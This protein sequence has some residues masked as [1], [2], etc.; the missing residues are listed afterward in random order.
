[1]FDMMVRCRTSCELRTAVDGVVGVPTDELADGALRAELLLVAREID[2]LEHRRARLLAAIHRRG[3]PN[4]DGAGSTPAWAQHLT[5]QARHDARKAL[6]AG[7]V[8][9]TLPLTSKAW[10]QGEI[11][12]GAALAICHGRPQGH[13]DAY[14]AIEDTLVEFAS[15]HDWHGLLA[16]VA[17]ARRCAD[18]L[19]GKEPSDLNGLSHARVGDRW[20]TRAD[21]DGL[22]GKIVDEALCAA[23]DK[24][25]DDDTRTPSKRFA[26]ALVR[27]ARFFL[28][29]EDL[30]VEGGEKPH[31]G[32]V[33]DWETIAGRLPSAGEL[34][35]SLSAADIGTLL[36]DAQIER[37]I[38]GAKRQPLDI[39]RLAHDVPKPMRRA[40]AARDRCCRFPGCDRRGSW[41]DVHHVVAWTEGGETKVTNLVLLCPYHHHLI[42]RRGWTTWFDGVTFEVYKPNGEYV[43]ATENAAGARARSR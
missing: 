30:P 37:I 33:L 8:C 32:I 42:H 27:I 35:P 3:I 10:A 38:T 6:L 17:H 2:R 21:L 41:C 4:A 15:A 43:G 40:V 7:R 18:A 31:L 39:G 1:M 19:D 16:S 25:T 13:E 24:P 28:D 11:S 5:G 22:S 20:M 36:C 9:E 29:H 12:T 34:G 14:A 26:D 23:T